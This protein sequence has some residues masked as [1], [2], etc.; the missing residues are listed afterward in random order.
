M[1]LYFTVEKMADGS[2][3]PDNLR[4]PPD[5]NGSGHPP[6]EASLHLLCSFRSGRSRSQFCARFPTCAA[7]F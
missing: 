3:S 7:V 4:G 1:I 6:F 2:G 5:K